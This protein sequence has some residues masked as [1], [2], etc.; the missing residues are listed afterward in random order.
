MSTYDTLIKQYNGTDWDGILPI[1][2]ATNVLYDSDHNM[3]DIVDAE[4]VARINAI[5][6]LNQSLTKEITD[7]DNADKGL[8]FN[9]DAEKVARENDTTTATQNLNKEILDRKNADNILQGNIDSEVTA[10]GNTDTLLQ[11]HIDNEATTRGN[12]DTTLQQHIDSEAT[13]R[14]NADKALQANIDKLNYNNVINVKAFGAKGDN[15]TDD[16]NALKLAVTE[17]NKTGGIIYFPSGVYLIT[18]TLVF[19]H[20]GTTIIGAGVNNTYIR[21]G[22]KDA[23]AIKLY[24]EN[25]TVSGCFISRL[26]MFGGSLDASANNS[27]GIEVTNNVNFAM[28]N[29]VISDFK[30]GVH[31]AGTGNSMFKSVGMSTSVP[32]AIGFFVGDRSVSN[33]YVDV[34]VGFVGGAVDSG[35]GFLLITGDIADQNIS[36]LD[37]GNGA[38]GLRIDGSNSP[39]D[40]PPTD[41]NVYDGVFDGQRQACVYI[42]NINERG[43]VNLIGGWC[44]PLAIGTAKCITMSMAYNVTIDDYVMQQLASTTPAIYAITGSSIFNLK[45]VHCNFINCVGAI[46]ADGVNKGLISGNIITL[47]AGKSSTSAGINLSNSIHVNITNNIVDGVY[48]YGILL[49]ANDSYVIVSLNQV[50][51][52]GVAYSNLSTNGISVNNIPS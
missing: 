4:A 44:N 24:K 52:A 8:Q 3:K 10:R 14:D 33:H 43:S 48:G 38:Y 34:Y 32:N 28:E 25:V 21:M 17:I 2:V 23:V 11:Q 49:S 19:T 20:H 31:C 35:I 36:Y 41:I 47:Y 50:T 13:T 39:T 22:N 15:T 29:V 1:T 46:S 37:V 18:D 5:N 9:I 7:R 45:V 40:Y 16:T 12:A 26:S 27:T 30:T 51:G 42:S 6:A